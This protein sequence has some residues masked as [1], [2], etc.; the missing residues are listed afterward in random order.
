MIGIG[1]AVLLYVVFATAR[2]SI[3]RLVGRDH[4]P[5]SW[6]AVVYRL[7]RR[8]RSF[9]M[10]LAAIHLV[11]HFVAAPGAWRSAMS[12]LFT[13][14]G[15]FQGAIWTR[16]LIL[17]LV[18]RRAGRLEDDSSTLA[19]ARGIIAL[20]VNIAVWALATILVLDNLGVNVTALV[21][22]LGVG[23][24]AIGLAAQGIFADLFAAL[25]ILFDQPFRRGE[26]I[27]FGNVTGT[28]EA[29][30]LKTTRVRAVSGEEV[31]IGNTKLLSD[32]IRNLR[33]I[34]HRTVTA[35]LPLELNTRT[36]KL[37]ALP[38]QLHEAV[39]ALDGVELRRAFIT[40]VTT[41]AIELELFFAVAD[42]DYDAMTEARHRVLLAALNVLAA[43]DILL[44]DNTPRPLVH[45]G[46][47][48]REEHRATGGR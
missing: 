12:F 35:T 32:P 36:A 3:K 38:A 18:D 14:A 4:L 19:S 24:I 42:P 23:G 10:A 7:V 31:I 25:A 27:S 37:L 46:P 39:A 26:S 8:T 34:E 22:G 5:A 15:A 1:A 30:G 48:L 29:I 47:A 6:R 43:E 28:V 11:S 13:I 44:A 45:R 41:T 2:E 40:G 9:F 20:L 16:E 33:R 17:G 21:A